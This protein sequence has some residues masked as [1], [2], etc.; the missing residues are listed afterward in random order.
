MSAVFPPCFFFV[1]DFLLGLEVC[2][3]VSENI[4]RRKS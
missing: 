4:V 3:M 2:M 1:E